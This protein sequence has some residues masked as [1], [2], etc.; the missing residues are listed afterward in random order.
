MLLFASS[1]AYTQELPGGQYERYERKPISEESDTRGIISVGYKVISNDRYTI[2]DLGLKAGFFATENMIVGFEYFYLFDESVKFQPDPDAPGVALRF[3]YYSANVSY[4]ISRS[5]LLTSL[6]VNL[7][8][9]QMNFTSTRGTPLLDD[10]TGDWVTVVE[11]VANVY[12][13]MFDYM[14]LNISAGYRVVSG[15][16][17]N[18][19]ENSD[20]SGFS[21]SIGLS[22]M[23]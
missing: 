16:E 21:S 7:G 19:L 8:F 3:D 18:D 14:F 5:F 4:F 17:Y 2:N 1:L 20:M 23:F 15:V 10:M 11:P 12:V 6:G 22:Y 9:G 13:Q